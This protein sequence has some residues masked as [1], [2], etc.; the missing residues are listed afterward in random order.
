MCARGARSAS[1]T[2]TNKRTSSAMI[3][4]VEVRNQPYTYPLYVPYIPHPQRLLPTPTIRAPNHSPIMAPVPKP[5]AFDKVMMAPNIARMLFAA[6]FRLF[7]RPID[8]SP[9]PV[10]LFRDVLFAALRV[11]VSSV[12]VAQEQ[13][14]NGTTDQVYLDFAKKKYFAP[15]T[16]EMEGGLKIHWLGPRLAK[17]TIL[18]FHGGGYSLCATSGHMEWLWDLKETLAQQSSISIVILSYTLAPEAQYPTQ[19]KQAVQA[20]DFLVKEKGAGNV[21]IS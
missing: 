6:I 5:S 18:Y 8:S 14:L 11:N 12:N 13:W 2:R 4:D 7:T 3:G 1:E 21:S 19:L 20:L 16:D 17:K 10:D 9:K 15:N